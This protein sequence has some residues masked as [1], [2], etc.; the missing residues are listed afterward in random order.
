MRQW[1]PGAARR[2]TTAWSQTAMDDVLAAETGLG[3]LV[4]STVYRFVL[5]V[6]S[7]PVVMPRSELDSLADPMG[8]LL[9]QGRSPLTVNDLLVEV[10]AAG[11]IPLQRSYLA[12]EAGQIAP[13]E[14]GSLQRDLRFVIT[15]ARAA[16][17]DLLISTSAVADQHT[18]FLQVAGWDEA[19]GRF[20]YYMRIDQSWVWTGDSYSAL[21]PESRGQG[22]F[23]SHVNGGLVMKELKQPWINWQSMNATILLAADDPLRENPL[24]KSLTGAEDLELTVRRGVSR[25]TAARLKHV[26]TPE[27]RIN[28]LDRLLR[29]LCT[30]TTVNLASSVTASRAVADDPAEPLTLPLGFWLNVESLLDDLGI[31][32]SFVPPSVPGQLYLDSLV[33]YDFAL[34]EG[35]FRQPGDTFFAFVVPEA[36]FEDIEVVNQMVRR[37]MITAHFVASVLMVDFPNPVFSPAR[38]KLLTYMPTTAALNPAGGGMSQLIAHAIAQAA[39][40]LPAD[41]PEAQFLDNW[42]FADSDWRGVFAARIEDY[43]SAVTARVSTTEGFDDYVRLA[44]SRRREFKRMRLNEFALTLPLTNIPPDAPLLQMNQDGTIGEKPIPSDT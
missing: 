5:G 17:V 16:D 15:R 18:T 41:S 26:V 8:V 36:A 31:P 44:E 25:W 2:R 4:P 30:S 21:A 14:A 3:Q 23:D 24:Y 35:E 10:D 11:E 12:G 13:A 19:A 33:H 7:E 6:D 22:C 43:L 9:R 32:A 34:V 29:Q 27:G 28:N 37:D 42:R 1:P 40:G 38:S 20:N 39:D